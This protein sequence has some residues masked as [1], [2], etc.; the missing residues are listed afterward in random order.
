MKTQ[1]PLGKGKERPGQRLKCGGEKR[2]DGID[3]SFK[4]KKIKGQRLEG[5]GKD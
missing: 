1:S 3:F 4:K 5:F 2:E